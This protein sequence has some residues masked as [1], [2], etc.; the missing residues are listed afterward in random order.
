MSKFCDLIAISLLFCLSW[1]GSRARGDDRA[2]YDVDLLITVPDA[3]PAQRDRFAMLSDLWGAAAQPDL[4]VD[5]VLNSSSEAACRA[6]TPGSLC[7]RPCARAFCSMARPEALRLLRIARRDLRM[8]R[9][10]LDPEVE[11]ASWGWAA[12]QCL[13]KT[14][15]AWLHHLGSA[16]PSIHATFDARH[17]P[18]AAALARGRHRDQASPPPLGLH[19]LRWS[20]PLPRRTR[21]TLPGS[22]GL[23]RQS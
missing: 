16:P 3:W 6:K 15:K 20:G 19:L 2:D 7:T 13:E 10:L 8:A 1:Y 14:L 12:Q 21:R 4:S 5:L 22:L 17:L 9:C 23:V 18:F 11:E